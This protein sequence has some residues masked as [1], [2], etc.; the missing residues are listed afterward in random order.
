MHPVIRCLT[1]QDMKTTATITV[2]LDEAT[3]R[4]L[5]AI[6]RKLNA[7][8]PR[9]GPIEKSAV[10]RAAIH[11]YAETVLKP[12]MNPQPANTEGARRNA[13]HQAQ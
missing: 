10:V 5:D 4:E 2:R 6:V 7:G 11:H 3:E 13:H 1:L 12:P 9:F 8:T